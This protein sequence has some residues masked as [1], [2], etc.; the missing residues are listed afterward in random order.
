[1]RRVGVGRKCDFMGD[2]VVFVRVDRIGLVRRVYI[3]ERKPGGVETG[4]WR[5]WDLLE[6][7]GSLIC[8]FSLLLTPLLGYS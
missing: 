7:Y 2:E 3:L 6:V 5:V 1:M 8:M 4:N